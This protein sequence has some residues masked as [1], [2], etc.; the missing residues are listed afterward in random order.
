MTF[1]A[2]TEVSSNILAERPA[3]FCKGLPGL[4]AYR[5][6]TGSKQ[7]KLCQH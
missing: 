7:Y 6:F 1:Q 4:C 5:R 3:S 2:Q